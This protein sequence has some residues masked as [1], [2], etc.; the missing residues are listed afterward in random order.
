M[1]AEPQ[2]VID[3][4]NTMPLMAAN[5]LVILKD[6]NA[7]EEK[8]EDTNKSNKSSWGGTIADYL[9]QPNSSTIL[10]VKTKENSGLYNK[11]KT[12]ATLVDC[13]KLDTIIFADGVSSIGY[14]YESNDDNYYDYDYY[15]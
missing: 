6:E 13:N 7:K 10:V 14:E 8:K 3:S 2:K 11:L 9:K 5:K 15:C 4:C 12:I 1:E